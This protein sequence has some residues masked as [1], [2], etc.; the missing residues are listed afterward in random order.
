[1]APY[2]ERPPALYVLL[3]V[4]FTSVF[5][6]LPLMFI[7]NNTLI[8]RRP[9]FGTNCFANRRSSPMCHLSILTSFALAACVPFR[10]PPYCRWGCLFILSHVCS[11]GVTATA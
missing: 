2:K 5:P 4:F 7:R 1:M 8:A 9:V 6:F 3:T 10:F 11:Q